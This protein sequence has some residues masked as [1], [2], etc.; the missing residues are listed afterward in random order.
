[1]M[2][3]CAKV[4][5]QLVGIMLAGYVKSSLVPHVKDLKVSRVG[6]GVMGIGG[7]KGAISVGLRIFDTSIAVICAHLGIGL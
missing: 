2:Y 1:M 4:A 5:E 3:V 6:V 7:N